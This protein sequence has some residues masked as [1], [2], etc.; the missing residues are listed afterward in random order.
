LIVIRP[1]C[2]GPMPNQECVVPAGLWPGDSAFILDT[3][4]SNM[5]AGTGVAGQTGQETPASRELTLL[6]SLGPSSC[7]VMT[8]LGV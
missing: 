6:V 8:P 2:Y 5:N 3:R 4:P 7:P 1:F